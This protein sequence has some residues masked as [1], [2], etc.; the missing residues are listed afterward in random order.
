MKQLSEILEGIDDGYEVYVTFVYGDSFGLA[1]FEMVDE[2]IY[3]N[4]EMCVAFT[5]KSLIKVS[6]KAINTNNALEFSIND[7]L[8]IVD[9]A[10]GGLIYERDS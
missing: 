5:I 2:T 1:D 7:I 3:N 6:S 8:K 4:T 10:N 9:P